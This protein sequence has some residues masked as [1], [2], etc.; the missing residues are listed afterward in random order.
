[1]T[2]LGHF[3]PFSPRSAKNRPFILL[4]LPD[5]FTLQERASILVHG[6]GLTG[7]ISLHLNTCFPPKGRATLRMCNARQFYYLTI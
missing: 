7:P 3:N 2:Q 1:M 5:D 4:W 6:K